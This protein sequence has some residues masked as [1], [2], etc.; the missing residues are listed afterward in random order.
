MAVHAIIDDIV[1]ELNSSFSLN[2]REFK[3]KL[4][5]QF[6]SFFRE[7]DLAIAKLQS[8]DSALPLSFSRP[9]PE[10]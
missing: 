8:S 4:G 10:Y 6:E 9:S 2:E 7:V 3:A 5:H 1:A